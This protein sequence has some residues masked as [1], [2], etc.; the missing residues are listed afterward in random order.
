ML[1][2]RTAVYALLLIDTSNVC[3]ALTAPAQR[4]VDAQS[5]ARRLCVTA[6]GLYPGPT[7]S[8][9]SF[10]GE[11]IIAAFV[12]EEEK[13]DFADLGIDETRR[14]VLAERVTGGAA[15][16]EVAWF[17]EL[18]VGDGGT[19]HLSVLRCWN[20][21]TLS[22]PHYH[23]GLGIEGDAITLVIDFP[24]RAEAG[25]ETRGPGGSYPEPTSREMFVLSSVRKEQAEKYFT[26]EAEAWVAGL[27]SVAGS[28]AVNL[29]G[30]PAFASP[31][32][33]SLRFP[34]SDGGLDWACE[35]A[36]AA[37]SLWLSWMEDAP[38]QQQV[39]TMN[40]FAHDAKVR[41][42]AVVASATLIDRTFG[43]GAGWEVAVAEAGP[44]DIAD[45]GSAQ[46]AAATSN[47]GDDEKDEASVAMLQ[48]ASEAAMDSADGS[49]D[50]DAT[51][52]ADGNAN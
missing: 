33:T 6:L 51:R 24:P 20:N 44:L 21:P 19:N 13:P 2:T 49:G 34:L 28:E 29:P 39:K 27:R 30:E 15:K 31:L 22:V 12:A 38:K 3:G 7:V 52:D 23:C 36:A 18:N 1:H 42:A 5:T 17:S 32:A 26:A 37:A 40:T 16:A 47:F 41:P 45:R 11:A 43:G 4:I 8:V 35:A 46:N 10:P 50:P 14:Q 48:L 9:P 25:Y